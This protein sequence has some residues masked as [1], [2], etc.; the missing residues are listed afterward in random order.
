MV[1][2]YYDSG[3]APHTAPINCCKLFI[4]TGHVH[5][6]RKRDELKP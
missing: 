4:P 5:F 6:M 1:S 3:A 2:E